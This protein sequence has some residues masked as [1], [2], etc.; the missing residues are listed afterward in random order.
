M[1]EVAQWSNKIYHIVKDSMIAGRMAIACILSK[2]LDY[3]KN[4]T[5][6]SN[7][8]TEHMKF[9]VTLDDFLI[10]PPSSCLYFV[11]Q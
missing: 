4:A 10:L 9:K 6:S 5:L 7:K 8:S 2:S 11:R 1:I 3:A